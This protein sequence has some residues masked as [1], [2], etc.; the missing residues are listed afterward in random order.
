MSGKVKYVPR[1]A[2]GLKKL[3]D[4]T[5]PEGC[6]PLKRPASRTSERGAKPV[7]DKY[8][9]WEEGRQGLRTAGLKPLSNLP[10]G[11]SPRIG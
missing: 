1:C 4:L 11:M 2:C 7:V 8:L 5:C 9:S 10:P 6:T 3:P